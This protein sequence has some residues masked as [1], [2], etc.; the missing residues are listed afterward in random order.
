MTLSQSGL[1]FWR[2]FT[3]LQH[4]IG[5][6]VQNN[7]PCLP[8]FEH[9]PLIAIFQNYFT[10]SLYSLSTSFKQVLFQ[11]AHRYV[12]RYQFYSNKN[13]IDSLYFSD[14]FCWSIRNVKH[15]IERRQDR[16][17]SS[18]KEIYWLS[19]I[20]AVEQ[21]IRE[22]CTPY[23]KNGPLIDYHPR[24]FLYDSWLFSSE[25]CSIENQ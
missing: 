10:F 9:T 11:A 8:E 13:L 20:D 4:A 7:W 3:K 22:R 6:W 15:R 21:R 14:W 16:Q 24:T 12:Y 2:H 17:V 23:G 25:Y 5:G 18:Y 19:C 1:Y